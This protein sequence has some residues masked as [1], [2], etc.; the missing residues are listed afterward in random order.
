MARHVA[1][2][3]EV[4]AAGGKLLVVLQNDLESL[5]QDLG[6]ENVMPPTIACDAEGELYRG[7]GILPAEGKMKMARMKTVVKLARAT[8]VGC[9]HG[10]YERGELQLPAVL[11]A[12]GKGVII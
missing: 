1:G 3:E 11:A 5:V 9:E 6:T 7:Y 12:D 10:C 2:Y 4:R 8:V